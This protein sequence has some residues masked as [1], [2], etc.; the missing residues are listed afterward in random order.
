[1]S[2][3]AGM[4][5]GGNA[6][7]PVELL[8]RMVERIAFRGP[9]ARHVSSRA[10][11]GF[12][13]TL[14]RTGPQPQSGSQPVSVDSRLWL[15]GD[16]RLDG[17]SD[18]EHALGNLEESG[19]KEL[20]DEELALLAWAK[21]G[22]ACLV[23][24]Y[25]EYSFAVWDAEVRRGWCARDLMG[26][27][28]LF[29]AVSQGHLHF[30][31]TLEAVLAG[32]SISRELDEKFLGDFLL[33]GWCPDEART[34]Y[35]DIRRLPPGH[36]GEFD[37]QALRLSRQS[38]LPI[39]DPLWLNRPEEYVQHYRSLLEMAVRDRLPRG[40]TAVFMS[41]GLDSTTVAAFAAKFAREEQ[42]GG[43]VRAF[44]VDYRPLF[45]DQEAPGA[46]QVA[47]HAGMAIEFLRGAEALPYAGWEY[48][49]LRTPEPCHEPFLSSH[50]A[51][52]R[53]AAR[54]ARVSFTG[55]GGD[56]ILTGQSWPMLKYLLA[57]GKLGKLFH[58]FG[59]YLASHGRF[60]PL[61]GGFRARWKRLTG[62]G[63]IMEGFP[64]WIRPEFAAKLQ[65]RG[66][67]REL[68]E[69]LAQ[70]HPLHPLAYAMLTSNYWAGV[71]EGEDA[72]RS[73]VPIQTRY[74]LL[75]RRVLQFLL[76]VPPV[77]WCMNKEL[78]RQAA[79]GIL[80]E[81]IRLRP[82]TPLAGD[83]LALHV[84]AGHWHPVVPHPMAQR[85]DE[86]I[87]PH[88]WGETISR[89]QGMSLWNDLR[90]LS[91]HYWLKRIEKGP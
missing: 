43:D 13:F 18:L 54:H 42:R 60:P 48:D 46:E 10:G 82:K 52:Y 91:L 79:R 3:F 41:G 75:D 86:M 62:R 90:P 29:Y 74:P 50:V 72:V 28:P 23:R 63:H 36:V 4:F 73:C 25:G 67:W 22:P 65:L 26:T 58:S 8:N 21:W 69:P 83:P 32:P 7:P 31:N 17:R 51:H 87:V 59:S 19:K 81:G 49:E 61:R 68:Q 35:Q 6:T 27:R 33:Q 12:C 66:R 56:D 39:E 64:A 44:T 9:D 37:G 78:L 16:V 15:V 24:L 45:D 1:M 30:S 55:D 47:R 70:I 84:Q 77:P 14:L 71:L 88:V 89:P 76:R 5:C 34:V 85:L 53:Q 20:T 40:R 57:R 2:G 38:A 11:A 80:P